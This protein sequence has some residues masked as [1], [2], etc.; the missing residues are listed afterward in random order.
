MLSVSRLVCIMVGGGGG[1][2]QKHDKLL[3]GRRGK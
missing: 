2:E 1:E 3:E